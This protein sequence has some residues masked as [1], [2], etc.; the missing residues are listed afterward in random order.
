[1]LDKKVLMGRDNGEEGKRRH[2][3]KGKGLREAEIE[4]QTYSTRCHLMDSANTKATAVLG[5]ITSDRY[6]SLV[7]HHMVSVASIPTT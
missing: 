3:A 6:K 5:K 4:E 7:L 1:M 2:K